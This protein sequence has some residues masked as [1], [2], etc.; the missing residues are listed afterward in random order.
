MKFSKTVLLLSCLLCSCASVPYLGS[1]SP[2]TATRQARS[3]FAAGHPRLY[4]A[5]GYASYAPGIEGHEKLVKRLPR[6]SSL[7]G[8]TNPKLQYS[9]EFATA[10]NKEMILLLEGTTH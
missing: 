5:G 9:K 3:D 10:Y 7:A 2:Q 1:L 6:D 8:C 4:L